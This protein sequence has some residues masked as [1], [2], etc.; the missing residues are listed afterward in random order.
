MSRAA[1]TEPHTKELATF[2]P[3]RLPYHPQIETAFG[4]TKAAWKTL[5]DVLYRNATT[6]DSV[7]LVLSYCKA[8]NLDP[9][10]K[11]VHIVPIWDK[12]AKCLVDT[13]WPGIGELRTTAFRTGQYAGRDEADFG[14]T[15][16]METGPNAEI[17]YPE[18]CRVTLYRMVQGQRIAFVGP[19][20]YWRETYATNRRDSDLPNE[21]WGTRPFGQLEKCAE[22]AALRA[23]FPEEIGSGD[24][25]PEEVEHGRTSPEAP[26]KAAS[27]QAA[28]E[29]LKP[30][31]TTP[32][33]TTQQGPSKGNQRQTTKPQE[34]QAAAPAGKPDGGDPANHETEADAGD[35][36]GQDEPQQ[37]ELSHIDGETPESQLTQGT[38]AEQPQAPT[39][40]V[41]A[42]AA[43]NPTARRTKPPKG[44]GHADATPPQSFFD[45]QEQQAKQPQNTKP[46]PTRPWHTGGGA[47]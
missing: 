24:Y 44:T 29:A 30:A 20:V 22:A 25:I 33:T 16:V 26:D 28:I 5:T 35:G 19:K 12:D 41:Q 9:M 13:V 2:T 15:L 32:E 36:Q 17:E 3:A 46:A 4:I 23:T 27:A 38:D 18:W 42:A 39:P 45:Q 10:K 11:P 37:P 8:R 43:H 40:G 6:P 47:R 1:Q 21:T 31:P 14:E 7:V 34:G